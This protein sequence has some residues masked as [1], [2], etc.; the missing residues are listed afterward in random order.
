MERHEKASGTY[1]KLGSGT[2]NPHA[3]H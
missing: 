2:A 1:Q 3:E